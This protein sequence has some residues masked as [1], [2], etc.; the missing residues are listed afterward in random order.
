M[1]CRN[2]CDTPIVPD[3]TRN[4]KFS[5]EDNFHNVLR[6]RAQAWFTLVASRTGEFQHDLPT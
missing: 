4:H 3:M 6:G 2:T 1:R 5:R